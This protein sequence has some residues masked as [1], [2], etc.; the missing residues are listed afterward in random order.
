MTQP[1]PSIEVKGAERATLNL[2]ELGVRARALNPLE[3]QLQKVFFRSDEASFAAQGPGWPSLAD[4][5]K[6]RKA[7]MEQDPR[8]LRLTQRL[9]RSLTQRGG[10]ATVR[11]S[12]DQVRFST[13]VPYARFHKHGTAN[14]PAREMELTAG[15]RDEMAHLI[16]DFVAT[17]KT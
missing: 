12:E 9:F 2:H 17:G 3:P 1:Q 14:M 6:E 8:M 15:E 13:T 10:E 5:T 11:T 4:S 16:A 7:A